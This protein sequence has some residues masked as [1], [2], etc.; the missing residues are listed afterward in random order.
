MIDHIQ[1][2]I[3][4]NCTLTLRSRQL[5]V[6]ADIYIVQSDMFKV[7]STSKVTVQTNIIFFQTIKK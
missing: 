7:L 1:H 4:D 5:N 6:M 2:K 3:D